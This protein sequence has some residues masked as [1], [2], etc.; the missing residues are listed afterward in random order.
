MN[1]EDGDADDGV[2]VCV[3]LHRQQ[4]NVRTTS[5]DAD[6]EST[7]TIH[8][9]VMATKNVTMIAQ[10]FFADMSVNVCNDRLQLED[11]PLKHD[12]KIISE[13][14]HVHFTF[15]IRAISLRQLSVFNLNSLQQ[16][17]TTN[18]GKQNI[19][20]ASCRW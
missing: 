1:D 12:D 7:T 14:L 15:A 5:V 16:R 2:C 18:T 17:V 9:V 19:Y 20:L 6:T 11:L 3:S 4:N 8:S 10:W 13:H